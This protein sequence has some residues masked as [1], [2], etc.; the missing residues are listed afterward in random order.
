LQK[1]S[2]NTLEEAIE[3]SCETLYKM[4]YQDYINQ[5][6]IEEEIPNNYS[7]CSH[8]LIWYDEGKTICDCGNCVEFD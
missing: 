4:S 3:Q 7:L 1:K 5:K 6:S 2:S 8:C